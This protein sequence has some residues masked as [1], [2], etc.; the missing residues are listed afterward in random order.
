[1]SYKA[2]SDDRKSTIEIIV[3]RSFLLA[4]FFECVAFRFARVEST[5]EFRAHDYGRHQP[6]RLSLLW[7][8]GRQDTTSRSLGD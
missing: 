4:E 8:R 7:Q 6:K 3:L 2:D 1:M 5:S